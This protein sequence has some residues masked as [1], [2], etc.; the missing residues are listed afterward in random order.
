MLVTELGIDHQDGWR[1][2]LEEGRRTWRLAQTHAVVRDS[3]EIAAQR[4]RKLG[5][6]VL[7]PEGGP[8]I[9]NPDR[10]IQP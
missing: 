4:L 8:P 5:Y 9:G 1:H 2:S 10:L 3:P 6:T 7:E